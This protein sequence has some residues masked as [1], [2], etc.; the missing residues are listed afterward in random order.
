MGHAE[1]CQSA[2]SHMHSPPTDA[3]PLLTHVMALHGAGAIWATRRCA[4]EGVEPGCTYSEESASALEVD[5]V[6]A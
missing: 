1:V 5:M 2:T 6:L 4:E 3:L